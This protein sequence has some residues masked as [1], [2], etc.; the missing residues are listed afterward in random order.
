MDLRPTRSI[1]TIEC[2]Q[3][4]NRTL[5]RRGISAMRVL[6]ALENGAALH[7]EHQRN[8]DV[9]RLS[10]GEFITPEI[11]ATVIAS[12]NVVDVGDSLFPGHPG[13][14]WRYVNGQ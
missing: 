12:Q 9:W 3:R 4:V 5:S 7:C 10:S 14:T 6:R 1:H 8:R 11:A 2:L 13:Q